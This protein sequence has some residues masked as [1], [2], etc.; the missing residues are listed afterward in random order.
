MAGQDVVAEGRPGAV[1]DE[2]DDKVEDML[3]EE[4]V[5]VMGVQEVWEVLDV[6]ESVVGEQVLAQMVDVDVVVVV[7]VVV[8]EQLDPVDER[9][10]EGEQELAQTVVGEQLDCVELNEF[11]G[12]HEL[13]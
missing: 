12:E 13:A 9:L 2:L 10:D 11:V 6:D 5:I 3:E 7:V 4:T 1:K 8:G